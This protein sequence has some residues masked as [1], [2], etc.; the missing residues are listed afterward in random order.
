MGNSA[1]LP[2]FLSFSLTSSVT[3]GLSLPTVGLVIA[4]FWLDW[5]GH[6]A[7]VA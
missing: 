1:G 4:S 6:L 7:L 2:S 3:L 5:L